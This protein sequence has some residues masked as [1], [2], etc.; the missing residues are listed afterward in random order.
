MPPKMSRVGLLVASSL[1][2]LATAG[3]A[4]ADA[5]L[6]AGRTA[7]DARV[8]R[9][10]LFMEGLSLPSQSADRDGNLQVAQFPNWPNLFN[11]FPN[12]RNL[13]TAPGFQNFPNFPNFLNYPRLSD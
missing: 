9:A 5:P 13:S 12:F 1:T 4:E 3:A 7:L 6:L 8:E 2:A 11:N 10:A